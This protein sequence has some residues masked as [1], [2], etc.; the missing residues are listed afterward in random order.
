M[1]ECNNLWIETI[2]RPLTSKLHSYYKD[3]S[4]SVLNLKSFYDLYNF[5]NSSRTTTIKI[6]VIHYREKNYY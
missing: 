5:I 2:P 6:Y 4:E 3:K 1:N